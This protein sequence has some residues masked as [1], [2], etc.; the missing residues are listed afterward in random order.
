MYYSHFKLIFIPFMFWAELTER[1]FLK[2]ISKIKL[3]NQK[4]ITNQQPIPF[5]Q[6]AAYFLYKFMHQK[7]IMFEF[8]FG[9]V[10]GYLIKE[11]PVQNQSLRF[12]QFI[13]DTLE[14]YP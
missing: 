14:K 9:K 10:F 11:T 8:I 6:A 3:I 7:K 13:E 5:L 4:L 2:V 1:N 12:T